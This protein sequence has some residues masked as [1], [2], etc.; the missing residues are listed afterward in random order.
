MSSLSEEARDAPAVPN[1][2]DLLQLLR[3]IVFVGAFSLAWITLAPFQSLGRASVLDVQAG[4]EV[5]TYFVFTALAVFFL[6]AMPE[7]LERR[8][9]A[10]PAGPARARDHRA[11]EDVRIAWTPRVAAA[12]R[13]R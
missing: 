7:R 5:V 9:A 8:F 2:S 3:G 11:S 4:N 13:P 12:R 6:W 10:L 1:I